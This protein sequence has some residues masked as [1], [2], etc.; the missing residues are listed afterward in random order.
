MFNY[1]SKAWRNIR[2]ARLRIDEYTCQ[3]CK[4]YGKRVTATTVHHIQPVNKCR[5]FLKYDTRNLISLCGDC[6]EAMHDRATNELTA[7]GLSLLRRKKINEIK[8]PMQL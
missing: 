2:E 5:E 8:A 7:R 4:R 6:H 1:H 3:E